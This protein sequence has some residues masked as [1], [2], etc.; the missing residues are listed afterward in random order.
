MLMWGAPGRPPQPPPMSPPMPHPGLKFIGAEPVEKQDN[1]VSVMHTAPQI[2]NVCTT[3][4]TK[5]A[6]SQS[7]LQVCIHLHTS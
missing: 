2:Q 1:A 4:E 5:G 3:D 6:G 7:G